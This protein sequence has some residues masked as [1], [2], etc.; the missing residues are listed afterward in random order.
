MKQ[1]VFGLGNPGEKYAATRHNVGFQVVE[2]LTKV[3][4]GQ[5]FSQVSHLQPQ[6]HAQLY[7]GGELFFSQP[8]TYMNDSGLAVM[9]V[10]QYFDK[11]LLV[12][13]KK[14]EPAGTSEAPAVI[15]IYDDLDIPLGQ[16]KIQFG[17]GPKVHN[18]LNSIRDH[19]KNDAFLHVRV[20]IDGRQGQRLQSGSEYVLTAFH[21]QELQQVEIAFNQVCEE[22]KK[23][24]Q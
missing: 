17:K 24:L 1:F 4:C 16:W 7:R 10:I 22:L 11:D 15:V 2:R 21:G 20:G 12:S 5:R 8:V 3:V 9:K 19:L 6:L 14:G 13:L 23:R 18:G